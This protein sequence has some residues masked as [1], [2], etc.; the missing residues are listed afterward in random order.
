VARLSIVI[1]CLG[2]AAEFDGALVSVLQNRPRDCEVIVA[3]RQP[4]DDPYGL[5]DE[6]TFLHCDADSLVELV[7]EAL[8][9]A[10]GEILHV[11]GCGLEVSENWTA[12]PLA[13]FTDPD[14]ASVSPLV[15]DRD[16]KLL[17]A[18]VCCSLGGARRVATNPR[19]VEAGSGRLRAKILGATLTAGFYRRDCLAALGGFEQSMTDQLADV[20]AALAFQALGKLHVVEPASR[21]TKITDPTTQKKSSLKRARALERLYWRSAAD[22]SPALTLPFHAAHVAADCAQQLSELRLLPAL[23]GRALAFCELGA[24]RRYTEQLESARQTLAELSELRATRFKKLP[25]FTSVSQ[26]RRKAA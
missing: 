15:F 12:A 20:A 7:N 26:P 14:V 24:V 8:S 2:D 16:Q 19:L 9:E 6:V 17:A 21:L 1:P 22:H 5:A 10:S 4:Y 25:R 18:G 13:H 11:L 3:H 23:V